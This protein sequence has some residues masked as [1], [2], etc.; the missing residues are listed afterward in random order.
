MTGSD[1]LFGAGEGVLSGQFLVNDVGPQTIEPITGCEIDLPLPP[2]ATR[3]VSLPGL[4]AF[5]STTTPTETINFYQAALAEAEWESLADP[6]IGTDAILLSYR[7]G[8]QMLE[9]NI[10]ASDEGLHVELLFGGD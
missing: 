4:I 1:P 6:Q 3:L 10:E 9:I 8:E 2:D 5:E 7:R